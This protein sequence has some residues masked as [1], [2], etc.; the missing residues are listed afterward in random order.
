MIDLLK[1]FLE[2]ICARAISIWTQ[3]DDLL[4][5]FKTAGLAFRA[6]VVADDAAAATAKLAEIKRLNGTV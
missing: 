1:R 4:T 6:A 3:A 2:H 5:E